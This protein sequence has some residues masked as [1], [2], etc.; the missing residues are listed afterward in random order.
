MHRWAG[1]TRRYSHVGKEQRDTRCM[2]PRTLMCMASHGAITPCLAQIPQATQALRKCDAVTLPW[3]PCTKATPQPT[4]P[5]AAE[6]PCNAAICTRPPSMQLF[7]AEHHLPLDLLRGLVVVLEAPAHAATP[8]HQQQQRQQGQGPAQEQGH[9]QGSS[10]LGASAPDASARQRG[11]H[12]A[13][14][15]QGGA[16]VLQ[17]PAGGGAGGGAVEAPCGALA[18][19]PL[20]ALQA[21][22]ILT[23]EDPAGYDTGA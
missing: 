3:P 7:W 19:G 2:A 4:T 15:E 20:L 18:V 21:R 9:E 16:E 14:G 22:R 17:G 12:D 23:C 11:G 5:A 10:A 6:A 1:A 13:S 8:L